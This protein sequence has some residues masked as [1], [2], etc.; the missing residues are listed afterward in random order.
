MALQVNYTDKRGVA[1][2]TA[3]ALI[4]QIRLIPVADTPQEDFLVDI[5]HTAAARGKGDAA[6]RQAT[7]HTEQYI[8]K[9][10]DFTTYFADGVLDDADKNIIKQGYAYLKTLNT[11]IDFTG[12]SDV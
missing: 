2:S 7:L 3:Y 10:S 1:S 5:Y 6:A 9:G 12:A 4:S 11:P 8:I